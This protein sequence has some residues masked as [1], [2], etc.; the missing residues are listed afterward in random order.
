MRHNE[1]IRRLTL[2]VMQRVATVSIRPFVHTNV[3]V[4]SKFI[5]FT[6]FTAW[7]D[8]GPQKI[9]SFGEGLPDVAAGI[10]LTNRCLILLLRVRATFEPQSGNTLS[11]IGDFNAITCVSTLR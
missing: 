1:N 9:C 11:K 5:Y 3:T 7:C 2:I 8:P 6:L 4:T 10:M